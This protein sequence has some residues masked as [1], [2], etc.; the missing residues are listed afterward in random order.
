MQSF[1]GDAKLKERLIEEI[2]K[3]EKADAI[4]QGTYGDNYNGQWKGCAVGCS[5]K[6]MNIIHGVE[7]STSAHDRYETELGIPRMIAKLEDRIFE[8]LSVEDSKTWPR[9]FAEAVPVGADLSKVW[10]Q[11]AVWIMEKMIAIDRVKKN[12]AVLKA[13]EDVRDAYARLVLGELTSVED[14]IKL[15][16]AAADAADAAYAAADAART[17][18]YREM[19]EK[20]LELLAACK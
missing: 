1:L 19:S 2:T 13:I 15:R 17:A 14:W 16:R 5:L 6:S 8:G 18:F 3:H 7:K 20:L 10:P 9:R 4:I 12:V 11:L